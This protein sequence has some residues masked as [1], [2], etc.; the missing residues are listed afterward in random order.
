MLEMFEQNIKKKN[1][2]KMKKMTK[3][4]NI[5]ISNDE[6]EIDT[7]EKND[8]IDNDLSESNDL[9]KFEILQEFENIEFTNEV[10]KWLWNESK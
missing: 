8:W 10:N 9:T 5:V 4:V 1:T 6:E 7:N 2:Q 3:N